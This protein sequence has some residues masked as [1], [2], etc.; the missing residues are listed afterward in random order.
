M[1]QVVN[2][3]DV[4]ELMLT[5]ESKTKI[6]NILYFDDSNHHLIAPTI[7]VGVKHGSASRISQS[8]NERCGCQSRLVKAPP[9]VSCV[10]INAYPCPSLLA[11]VIPS[12]GRIS[13]SFIYTMWEGHLQ[14]QA[15]SQDQ[16]LSMLLDALVRTIPDQLHLK[17]CNVVSL[18][19]HQLRSI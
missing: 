12:S 14:H 3:M 9:R 6:D 7:A 18:T 19:I 8:T 5:R 17:R 13:S 1:V 2:R 11:D 15:V 16:A 10:A 4:P